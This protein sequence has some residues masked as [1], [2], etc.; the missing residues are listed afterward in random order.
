[1][2]MMRGFRMMA[3][4][5]AMTVPATAQPL[6]AQLSHC[7]AIPG[8]LQRLACYDGAARG[9]GIVASSPAIA[10][11][12]YTSAPAPAYRPVPPVAAYAPPPPAS[13]GSER[14]PQAQ[15][16]VAARPAQS[17][18]AEVTKLTF[19]GY[20]RFT[21]VLSNGEIWRQVA[22]DETFLHQPHVGTVRISRGLL[23]SYDLAVSGHNAVYKVTR[24]Q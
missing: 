16:V 24:L 4:V 12:A 9:A 19:D 14:L 8:V 5:A 21:M 13:L 15:A 10:A 17:L 22:G 11:P 7:L 3:A 20:G 18:S 6:Q 2:S 1:M 23:G